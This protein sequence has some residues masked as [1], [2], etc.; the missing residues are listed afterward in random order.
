MR[1]LRFRL[2]QADNALRRCDGMNI[3]LMPAQATPPQPASISVP[4]EA[5]RRGWL[6]RVA[7]REV[8]LHDHDHEYEGEWRAQLSATTAS[9]F[10]SAN[11]SVRAL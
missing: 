3:K 11:N 6:P 7:N 8:E 1:K 5:S 2:S 9:V 4:T 10:P